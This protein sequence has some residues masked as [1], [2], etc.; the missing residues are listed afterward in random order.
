[1][2]VADRDHLTVDNM[3]DLNHPGPAD[4]GDGNC[5][6]CCGPLRRVSVF[7]TGGDL[8]NIWLHP[9]CA[10]QLA[11]LLIKD[12]FNARVIERNGANAQLA[13]GVVPSLQPATK[14][15]PMSL[16]K[17]PQPRVELSQR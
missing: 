14:E 9:E 2:T 15:R 3:T 5:F 1:M 17:H 7:W 10:E 13:N 6:H 4:A 11:L 8:Q 16:S 12:A